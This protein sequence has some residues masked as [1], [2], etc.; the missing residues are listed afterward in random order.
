MKTKRKTASQRLIEL[1][2]PRTCAERHEFR[3]AL[4]KNRREAAR[5]RRAAHSFERTFAEAKS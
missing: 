5:L 4:A 2:F 3:L 1:L